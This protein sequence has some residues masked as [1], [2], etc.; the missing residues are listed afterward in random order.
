MGREKGREVGP[1][2]KCFQPG[3]CLPDSGHNSD[4]LVNQWLPRYAISLEDWDL[5]GRLDVTCQSTIY[6]QISFGNTMVWSSTPTPGTNGFVKIDAGRSENYPA[7]KHNFSV[8][9]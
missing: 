1:D 9:A 2:T 6:C 7:T 3:F 4:W 8:T 5:I